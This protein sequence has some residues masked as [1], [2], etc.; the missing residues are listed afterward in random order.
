[1]ANSPSDASRRRGP[2]ASTVFKLFVP[3]CIG[4]LIFFVPMTFDG[5]TTIPLDH[6]VTGARNLLGEGSGLYAWR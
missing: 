4:V 1:M 6:M 5:K 2:S 3:S